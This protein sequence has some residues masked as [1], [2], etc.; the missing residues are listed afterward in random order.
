MR[1][2]IAL[3]SILS[4]LS[5]VNASAGKLKAYLNYATFC[6]PTD[7][8]YVE[9]YIAVVGKSAVYS[10]NANGKFQGAIEITYIFK[11]DSVIKKIDKYMLL[12]PETDDTSNVKFTFIDQ[13]R[14]TLPN[15]IYDF[16]I[17]IVDKNKA[18]D[19]FNT[20]AKMSIDYSP[21]MLVISGIE[22]VESAIKTETNNKLTK[23]GYDLMPFVSNFYPQELK[24]L[25]FYC[26]I[27]NTDKVIGND[28]QYLLNYFVEVFET[29]KRLTDFSKF[30]R[31]TTSS[32]NVLLS[33]IPIEKLPSG[34]Y[35]LIVEVRNK[36]NELITARSLFFQRSN[37][38]VQM[39]IKDINAKN[40]ENSFVSKMTNKDSLRDYIYSLHP[41]STQQERAFVTKNI[42]TAELKLMQQ[43]F[44]NFWQERNNL[45]P[46]NA[47]LNYY[48]EVKKVNSAYG[49]PISKGYASERGRVYL[50]YGPPNSIA[51]SKNEPSSYP[52]EIWHYYKL[53]NQSNRKFIF[54]NQDLVTNDYFLLHSD[55][56]GEVNDPKWQLK[57]NKRNTPNNNI[58]REKSDDIFGGKSTDLYN[59]P[60]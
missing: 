14:I 27:Y 40:V 16:Y 49:T 20:T 53:N 56:I 51:E 37:P 22:T 7:G 48:D 39:E 19:V 10:K 45:N 23:S 2:I 42:K 44:L 1:K 32:V 34:N 58:D 59:N 31:Q 35:N 60:R 29:K 3:L 8:P 18:Q 52:Y 28:Q 54:C 6:S 13:Q 15:G 25:T 26:E 17:T 50:Q 12:S 21:E 5:A 47:W 43:Y 36:K 24:K 33:E 41:I 38:T 4:L 57:L 46:Q 55:A 30:K 11:Q 9:T